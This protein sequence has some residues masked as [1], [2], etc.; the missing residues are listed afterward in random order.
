MEEQQDNGLTDD[1]KLEIQEIRNNFIFDS[2]DLLKLTKENWI[3]YIDNNKE[4][5]RTFITCLLNISKDLKNDIDSK[6]MIKYNI[7]SKHFFVSLQSDFTR[8]IQSCIQNCHINV[9]EAKELDELCEEDMKNNICDFSA[10]IKEIQTESQKFLDL[11]SIDEDRSLSHKTIRQ[12][13]LLIFLKLK[14]LLQPFL[15]QPSKTSKKSFNFISEF[16]VLNN[17]FFQ[18]FMQVEKNDFFDAIK[19]TFPDFDETSKILEDILEVAKYYIGIRNCLIADSKEKVSKNKI[20]ELVDHF[21]HAIESLLNSHKDYF[22]ALPENVKKFY[23][24]ISFYYEIYVSPKDPETSKKTSSVIKKTNPWNGVK[25]RKRS[26][27]EKSNSSASSSTDGEQ[28]QAKKTNRKPPPNPFGADSKAQY[29]DAH[30]NLFKKGEEMVNTIDLLSFSEKANQIV[31]SFQEKIFEKNPSI[32]EEIK[33]IILQKHDVKKMY[34]LAIKQNAEVEKLSADDDPIET[35]KKKYEMVKLEGYFNHKKVIAEHF[36]K[37]EGDIIIPS[38]YCIR[39]SEGVYGKNACYLILYV[40]F[41]FSDI[42]NPIPLKMIPVF[43]LNK[44]VSFSSLTIFVFKVNKMIAN[45]KQLKTELPQ[46]KP[47]VAKE[48]SVKEEDPHLLE[49]MEKMKQIGIKAILSQSE[50]SIAK[51]NSKVKN[52]VDEFCNQNDIS[53]KNKNNVFPVLFLR[54][55]LIHN[56]EYNLQGVMPQ[57]NVMVK[58]IVDEEKEHQ[59]LLFP[60]CMSIIRLNKKKNENAV[61]KQYQ[62]F[63]VFDDDE[64]QILNKTSKDSKFG[65]FGFIDEKN[66]FRV[67][68]NAKDIDPLMRHKLRIDE[69]ETEEIDLTCYNDRSIESGKNH[70]SFVY[71]A[72]SK[73]CGDIDDI[74]ESTDKK[75][76]KAIDVVVP[77]KSKANDIKITKKKV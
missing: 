24:M 57:S 9:E 22:D 15:I 59:L 29:R 14:D 12:K 32:T 1:Q 31:E 25:S 5:K 54:K 65:F 19:E 49:A 71:L 30:L 62:L 7:N 43:T 13:I 56:D 38:D 26:A 58:F 47:D 69:D 53:R 10:K 20:S 27:Y 40:F 17:Y 46:K 18:M 75:T 8:I 66:V 72:A 36:D 60:T 77:K 64:G 3:Q 21:I 23:Y 48:K 76:K 35:E 68:Y 45:G 73:T 2:D 11:F 55:D 16:F 34:N 44:T 67:I 6:N 33:S 74:I 61:S 4:S 51:L 70:K 52:F 39:Y 50:V 63:F 28:S 42:A 41:N 37:S